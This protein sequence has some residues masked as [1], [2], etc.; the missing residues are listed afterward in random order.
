MIL[1]NPNHLDLEDIT[2]CYIFNFYH[3]GFNLDFY[4]PSLGA[5]RLY[6]NIE[7]MIGYRPWPL[8]KICWLY[9]TPAVCLVSRMMWATQ[10]QAA[11]QAVWFWYDHNT[12]CEKSLDNQ[13]HNS[14]LSHFDISL[15]VS[16]WPRNICGKPCYLEAFILQVAPT[17]DHSPIYIQYLVLEASR[18]LGCPQLQ[19]RRMKWYL[20]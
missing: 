7:D 18:Q 13:L 2:N 14:W 20:C 16:S 10:L 15:Y 17:L 1:K 11:F 8:M 3:P 9:I 5:D 4:I 12:N 19:V 6:D